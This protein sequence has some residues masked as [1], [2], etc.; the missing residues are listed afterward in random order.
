MNTVAITII[1]TVAVAGLFGA[2]PTDD[3]PRL[4]PNHPAM[5]L[6]VPPG[7]PSIRTQPAESADL[8]PGDVNSVD[9]IIGAYYDVISG[10][11]GTPRDWDRFRSLFI[12]EARFITT[13]PGGDSASPVIITPQQFIQLNRKYFEAGGY[14]EREIHRRR[15]GFGNIAHVFSTY[16]ARR[17]EQAPQPYSRGINSIQLL[18]TGGRWW[19][20][21][22]MWDHERP[23]DNTI[24][25]EYLP[26]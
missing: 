10:P 6:Q 7:H 26:M 11:A 22:V 24:P 8:I 18:N 23:N 4:P 2:Q 15:D 12:S 1:C 9:A 21:T 19:I 3:P 14:F 16:E 25:S 20:V 5:R 17:D 13:R